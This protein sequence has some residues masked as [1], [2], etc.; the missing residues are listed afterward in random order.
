M[1]LLKVLLDILNESKSMMMADIKVLEVLI[2]VP[3]M[4]MVEF[5]RGYLIVILGNM[6]VL[7]GKT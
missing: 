2:R 3:P 7:M 6:L 1:P 4:S 5:G